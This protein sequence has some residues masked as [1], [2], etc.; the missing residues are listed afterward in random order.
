MGVQWT[1][2]ACPVKNNVEG[3]M[4]HCMNWNIVLKMVEWFFNK[5]FTLIETNLK[6]W[7][8]G[9]LELFSTFVE[10]E[11][12][13]CRCE[14]MFIEGNNIYQLKLWDQRWN[15]KCPFDGKNGNEF[16]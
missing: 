13:Q 10:K 11:K 5:L 16:N 1:L 2:I 3:L 14:L 8:V 7:E 15:N 12:C 4:G 9:I 6:S